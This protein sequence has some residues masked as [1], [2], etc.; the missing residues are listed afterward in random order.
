MLQSRGGSAAKWLSGAHGLATRSLRRF[1]SAAH[2][3][4]TA[5]LVAHTASLVAHTASL[6]VGRVRRRHF[7]SSILHLHIYRCGVYT[8]FSE[9]RGV[10]AGC[11]IL[12]SPSKRE[13]ERTLER[14]RERERESVCVCVCVCVCVPL[15]V[16]VCVCVYVCVCDTVCVCVCLCVCVCVRVCV[17]HAVCAP[18]CPGRCHARRHSVSPE[19]WRLGDAGTVLS[20]KALASSVAP[21]LPTELTA[22]WVLY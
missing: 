15:C 18:T 4:H 7:R 13:I 19:R 8:A 10:R 21:E 14:E 6:V 1:V 16:C 5:S 3:A 2:T 9:A 12:N 22:I 11:D 17:D 20:T